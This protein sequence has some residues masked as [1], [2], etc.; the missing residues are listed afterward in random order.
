MSDASTDSR[1]LTAAEAAAELGITTSTLY[2]Y[3]S[4]GL[5]ASEPAPGD[6]RARRYRV[7]DVRRL[8][9]RQ[10]VRRNPT[11]SVR[12][13]L[14][15][16]VPLLESAITLIDD[17]RL[18]Y[19]GQDAIALARER[20]FEDVIA[21]LWAEESASQPPIS[22]PIPALAPPPELEPI[23][24]L[25]WVLPMLSAS[26]P[27]AYDRTPSAVVRA[28]WWILHAFVDVLTGDSLP[29]SPIASRIATAWAPGSPELARLLDA[30][31]ILWADHELNV[32]SFTVRCIMSAGAPLYAAISGGLA[33]LQGVKHGGMTLR[34][35]ALLDEIGTPER[36]RSVVAGRLRRGDGLPGFGHRLYPSGDPRAALLLELLD[37]AIGDTEIGALG[38][39]T[40]A[41]AAEVGLVPVID[42]AMVLLARAY[43]M[44]PGAPLALMAV[45][46][47]AGWVA[48]ALEEN[49]RDRLI[50]P[51]ARYTG[52]LPS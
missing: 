19:R 44:P 9:E 24:A 8:R 14:S 2:A 18:W 23:A 32:S 12:E 41:A 37:A 51:R 50:R 46:R 11:G 17:G 42:L 39:A 52:P 1:Y 29:D 48:H 3:V 10:D 45:G 5:I 36:A 43:A 26:D 21:L 47:T 49:E 28:G 4:R 20:C 27:T 35:D 6:V 38:R 25:Q 16:G 30:A 33:A 31:L 13:A 40:I 34:V 15:F 7:E 22:Q